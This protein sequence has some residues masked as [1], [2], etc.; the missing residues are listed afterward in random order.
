MR[1]F[2]LAILASSVAAAVE[3]SAAESSCDAPAGTDVTLRY[4]C[5]GGYSPYRR[6]EVRLG[7]DKEAV[8]TWHRHGEAPREVAYNVEE[9][10][11]RYFLGL[12]R[13]AGFF[14]LTPG[15]PVKVEDRST[16]TLHLR[17]GEK[18]RKLVYT[19]DDDHRIERILEAFRCVFAKCEAL[20]HV[21]GIASRSPEPGERLF[22][23]FVRWDMPL[24]AQRD[25][26]AEILNGVL[27]STRERTNLHS[28]YPS[29]AEV[30]NDRTVEILLDHLAAAYTPQDQPGDPVRAIIRALGK[31]GDMRAM[32]FLLKVLD[33]SEALGGAALLALA[34]LGCDAVRPEAVRSRNLEALGL[35]G[36]GHRDAEEVLEEE[37]FGLGTSRHRRD[38]ATRALAA[39]PGRRRAANTNALAHAL[40][41]LVL[42]IGL[43]LLVVPGRAGSVLRKSG[44][45]WPRTAG[46]V[47]VVLSALTFFALH[48]TY[49][50]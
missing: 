22:P 44:P 13:L 14:D 49:F 5:E 6:I 20:D 12:F 32:P 29:A 17:V 19:W 45:V 50:W 41:M 31:T 9:H 2:A 25:E 26:A 35:I 39:M 30:G 10:E 3:A 21:R 40:A 18:E 38:L 37:A 1:L 16:S 34:R 8:I 42:L 36:R 28:V 23:R 15:A 46:V 33:E 48:V 11:W 4:V 27:T 43:T 47:L 24:R 7:S